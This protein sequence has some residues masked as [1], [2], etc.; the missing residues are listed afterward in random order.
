MAKPYPVFKVIKLDGNRSVEDH[1]IYKSLTGAEQVA[2]AL[3][4]E[5]D[6]HQWHVFEASQWEDATEKYSDLN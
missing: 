1:R 4:R 2:K 6:T 3:N 5:E